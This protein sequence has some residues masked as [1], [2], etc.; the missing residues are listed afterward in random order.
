MDISEDVNA[1]I[2]QASDWNF[3]GDCALLELM[4]R[5]S[6]NLH[7]RG[8]R[9]TNNLI[10]FE[11]NVRRTDIALDNATNSLRSLQF[12]QQFVEYRVEEVEDDDFALPEEEVKKPEPPL[13]TSKELSEEFLQNNLQMFR[14]NFEA[15]T[16]EVSDSDEEDG[17][18]N[19]TTVFRDKNPYDAIP[20]PFIIGS[21]QW[22]EHKYAGLYDSAE[23]SEDEQPEQFSSSS[24]D[25]QEL[26]QPPKAAPKQ[27]WDPSQRSL[28]SDSS[29][30][31]SLPK[32]APVVRQPVPAAAPVVEG[33]ARPIAQ[34]RPIIS[35]HRNPH[36]SD[37]FAALRASPPSDDP[38]STSSSL[39]SSSATSHGIA[40][41]TNQ[42]RAN[43]SLSSSS[44]NVSRVV[45]AG[46]KQ[47]PPKLFD[48]AIPTIPAATPTAT[49]I[50]AASEVKPVAAGNQIK[51][52]PVNLFNDDEF[53]S[54]MSEIVDKVQAKSGSNSTQTA[55]VVKPKEVPV[56]QEVKSKPIETASRRP[57]LFEDSPPLSP[58]LQPATVVQPVKKVPTSLFDDNLDDDVDDFLSSLAPKA[59]PQPQAFKKSLF[60][61]DDDL[62]IDDIFVKNKPIAPP[63]NLTG[64]TALF[65]DVEE[66]NE[67][68]IFGK[69]P[70]GVE[71]QPA[72]APTA[73]VR[74]ANRKPT[75]AA[76]LA[77]KTFLF[78]DD[79]ADDQVSG[80]PKAVERQPTK[81]ERGQPAPVKPIARKQP[82]SKVSLFDD[83][84][85]DEQ[86]V[87]DIFGKD[88]KGSE[89][90][91]KLVEPAPPVAV[92][93]PKHGL[94]DDQEDDDLF[95]TP[96]SIKPV[97]IVAERETKRLAEQAPTAD[98]AVKPAEELSKQ[99][100]LEPQ[101]IAKQAEEKQTGKDST[102]KA[103]LPMLKSDLFN[104]DFSDREIIG[105]SKEIRA[106]E[107]PQNK[108][109]DE[110]P[111]EQAKSEVQ[112]MENQVEPP[113]K[114][115]VHSKGNEVK[116]E[117]LEVRPAASKFEP[118]LAQLLGNERETVMERGLADWKPEES[119]V[120]DRTEEQ[121]EAVVEDQQDPI[122]SLVAEL[123]QG[124]A[125]QEA[126]AAEDVAAAKQIMQN[127]SSLFSDEP[128]D[129]SEFF[130]S[131]GTSSLPSLGGSKMFDSEHEHDFYEPALPDLPAAAEA[132]KD[133]GGMRLF[134]D[135]PPDDDD[136]DQEAEQAAAAAAA[137]KASAPV[138]EESS[139]PKRIHTIFYDDFSETARAGAAACLDER[140]PA[141]VAKPSS[142]VKKL[143]MPNINI[144]VHALLPSAKLPKKQDE[145]APA[146]VIRQAPPPVISQAPSPALKE[147]PKSTSSEAENILQCVGKTRVRGPAH[148]RPSTR[149]ARQ[150]NY[151]QSLLESQS[152]DSVAPAAVPSTSATTSS[153]SIA[154]KSIGQ[155]PSFDSD[156]NEEQA[157]DD[158]LFK[159]LATGAPAQTATKIAPKEPQRAASA[160]PTL[161]ADSDPE[162][163]DD[164]LFGKAL[165]RKVAAVAPAAA[166]IAAPK[167]TAASAAAAET[168]SVAVL[169]GAP[170]TAS[171]GVTALTSP[172]VSTVPSVTPATAAS[173]HQAVPATSAA[174]AFTNPKPTPIALV[175]TLPPEDDVKKLPPKSAFFLDSD[176]DEDDSNSFFFSPASTAPPRRAAAG[177]PKSYVSFLD[178]NDDDEDALFAA[179]LSEKAAKSAPAPVPAPPAAPEKLKAP[180]KTFLDSDDEEEDDALFKPTKAMAQPKLKDEHK[181]SKATPLALAKEQSKPKALKT[182]LFDD[183]DDDDDLFS[184][185][186][187][188][189]T[190]SQPAAAISQ[191]T[192]FAS[193]E[194][195]PKE[196]LPKA[197]AKPVVKQSKSLFSDDED[198]DDLFGSGAAASVAPAGGAKRGAKPGASN[199]IKKQTATPIQ[200]SSTDIADNPLAD[201]LG[202]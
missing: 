61:D 26:V 169:K 103:Q 139:T 97:Y 28:Q 95:A 23:N 64:K 159:S 70:R 71:K 110:L 125:K 120:A 40:A 162:D 153:A 147:T 82:T 144:N 1:I 45:Q 90:K 80:A 142:P 188:N 9:T 122:I 199:A 104:D 172:T 146:P 105:D 183:S 78:D 189:P 187:A 200:G 87:E 29:S 14:K 106:V 25:E 11:T 163:D 27:Q 39:N 32:E 67:K 96:K 89:N 154:S 124:K 170:K 136:D 166:S 48:D 54:F 56:P 8:E 19:A 114:P 176:E 179:A 3:A 6:Q 201:L 98:A 129:D 79:L 168:A 36:E 60:D 160:K 2:S 101:Q 68:D 165:Q 4:K 128:P 53:N 35:M 41:A 171:A 51:R 86:L 186:A 94:F 38:P 46:G 43:V 47:S 155:L 75:E 102:D 127:Y 5:I 7:E 99:L 77:S 59:K 20:L 138:Q 13:K 182:Q 63:A 112:N 76:S 198:D 180:T 131:L 42:S 22:Q 173:V 141:N 100:E 34:P 72:P 24:S 175:S 145:P 158:A 69:P 74:T 190:K 181:D 10:Q 134:S 202:P 81:T 52:K 156:D 15:V 195:G 65:D 123:G 92:E 196:E 30:L 85:E 177:P 193:S 194:K 132:S 178:N 192:L 108:A 152:A 21:K 33:A 185:K 49:P 135:V 116:E 151:A 83:D 44:S 57:N 121:P 164:A 148:R 88:S 12:G 143:Q 149:R 119:V 117:E 130:Q 17:A 157:A 161:F 73:A 91:P 184:S 18:V 113:A 31:A 93:L 150:A 111:A 191:A 55:T 62:D 16:I 137:G 58:N 107:E 84:E 126:R 167:A 140:P 66:D 174:P 118:E 115:E 133:Y 109:A 197:K 37:L 50:A